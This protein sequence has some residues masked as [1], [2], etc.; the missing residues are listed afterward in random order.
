MIEI[1]YRRQGKKYDV[2][3]SDENIE[4]NDIEIGGRRTVT[5][6]ALSEIRLDKASIPLEDSFGADDLIMANG[7]QSWT[8]TEEF[9]ASEHL[10]DLRR[11]PKAINARYHFRAY[12]S[13][14]FAN[15]QND[16]LVGFDFSYVKGDDPLFIGSFNSGNAYLMIR[17]LR[18]SRMIILQSDVA[19]KVIGAG[20]EFTLFDYVKAEDGKDYFN[21]FHPVS[22]KKLFGYTSWYNHYQNINEEKI[23][24]A[25]DHADSRFD[26]FQ[27]DDGF[28][29][30]VGDWLYPDRKKFP[31]GLSGIIERIHEKGMMAGIWLAPL[32]AETESDLF[33]THQDWIPHESSGDPV[34]AGCNWS[35]FCPL[36][37]NKREAV[38]YIRRVLRKYVDLGFDFFKLDFLYAANLKPL[39]GCTRAE[40]TEYI[41]Q[42]IREELKGKLILGCGAILSNAAEKF[43][44]CRIGPDVSLTFD[45]VMYMRL[46]H[47]ERIST[48]VTIRNTIYR[49]MLN[50]RFFMNDPDVFLLR[51]NIKLTSDQRISLAG[52]NA[53]FGS[54]L[55]T[56]DDIGEY[57]KKKAAALEHALNLFYNGKVISYERQGRYILVNFELDGVPA[58]FRYDTI[59]GLI[60]R[61]KANQ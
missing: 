19:G 17:F 31:N 51:D 1:Q 5:V 61:D 28:E 42:L 12:G 60:I 48:K 41:Y 54:M 32:I 44:Y 21:S 26:L 3:A 9:T 37:L 8:E 33:R 24:D 27:I 16:E 22:S 11:I 52:I 34:Y 25:L 18:R 49:S 43:D 58:S 55:M 56:S 40:T 46:F 2:I 47:S 36:D 38:E 23:E 20:E 10:N 39:H 45:D 7:Y 59:K 57:R 35:G 15:V 4:I 14:V 50:G 30:H 13:Q 53:L 6:K 29:T